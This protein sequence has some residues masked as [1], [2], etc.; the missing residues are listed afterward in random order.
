MYLTSDAGDAIEETVLASFKSVNSA[1]VQKSG[2]I[3]TM[4]PDGRLKLFDYLRNVENEIAEEEAHRK[5]DVE[6]VRAQMAR[7]FAFNK[8]ARKKMETRLLKR[9]AANA[10][11]CRD[12][13]HRAM[14]WTQHKFAKAAALA[15]KRQRANN[16]RYNEM[17]AKVKANKK[18]AERNL[19]SKVL[20]QQ[21]AMAALKS[22][23]NAKIRQTNHEV[24]INAAQIKQ[25]AKDAHKALMDDVAKFDQKVANARAEAAKGRSKLAA[26]LV[27]QNKSVRQYATNK[28]KEE[29]AKTANHFRRVRTKMAKD[30]DHA[31]RALKIASTRM[32]ASLNA[33]SAMN[34]KRFQKT[35]K[36]IAAAKKEARARVKAAK[37]A[38]KSHILELRAQVNQQVAKT[39][40]RMKQLSGV[41]EKAKLAQA[42]VNANVEA[43]MTRMMK[44]GNKRYQQH[45]AKDKELL[46]TINKN[47]A[48]NDKR[49]KA[50]A[51]HYNAEMNAVRKTMAKNRAH[52]SH[53]LAKESAKLYGAIAKSE[54]AQLKVN[55]AL[56]KQTRVAAMD[57]ADSLR[58]AKKDFARRMGALHTT[59]VANDKKFEKKIYKLTGIVHADAVKNAKGRAHLASV[60]KANKA[61]LK[62]AVSDAIQKG[63]EQMSNAESK[64]KKL[65]KKTQAAL[66]MRITG[67]ISKLAARANGQIEGLRLSS[68][69]ARAEMK[70]ELLFAVRSAA[71]EAKKNLAAAVK[72]ATKAFKGANKMTT[73][74][75]AKSAKDRA[76]IAAKIKFEKAQAKRGLK[77]A[78]GTMEKS[79]LALGIE[80]RK[81]IKKTNR[82]ITAYGNA[83][84]KESKTVKSLMKSNMNLLLGKIRSASSKA[85]KKIRKAN[86]KSRIGFG[87]VY[88]T[89]KKELKKAQK[90][91]DKKFAGMYTAMSKNRAQM[92]NNLAGAVRTMNKKIGMQ[93][94][95]FDARFSKTVKN[96]KN[97]RAEARKQ[98]ADARKSFATDLATLTASVKDQETRLNGDLE[99]VSAMHISNKAFQL[100]VNRRTNAEL[101]RVLKLSNDQH[102]E[103]KRARGKIRKIMDETKRAAAEEVKNM[104]RVFTGKIAKIR[105]R[106]GKDSIEAARDL[107]KASSRMYAELANV[108]LKAAYSNKLSAAKIAKYESQAAG[109]IASAK[110]N[111]NARLNNLAN[112]VVANSKKV[113]DG[114]ETLTG[115]IRT[116]KKKS[117]LDRQLIRAQIAAQEKDMN[118]RI[119]RAIAKGEADAKRVAER[120]RMDLNGMQKSMLV[121]I[122]E[123]VEETADNLFKTIQNKHKKL[124]D[125]YMS[126]KAYAVAAADTIE[127]EVS[128]GKGKALSS[129][130]DLLSTLAS[131]THVKVGKMPGLGL[132]GKSI[133]AIFKNVKYK[134]P[135]K[136]SKINALVAQY[137][138]VVNGVRARWPLGLG[139]YLLMK[140]E[141]SM[142]KKGVLKVGKVQDKSGNFVF[143]NGHAVGLSNKLNDFEKLAVRMSLY[144][145]ALARL[146]ADMAGKIPGMKK[147]PT[148]FAPPEYQGK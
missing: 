4:T 125:N 128:K 80:T 105:S 110:K 141:E 144:E 44:L 66:N 91:S 129:L 83:L 45:L 122:S 89:V 98:V 134:V 22:S 132:G 82:K 17:N 23:M 130:G 77:D 115:I 28:L 53:M 84:E 112:L 96:I 138:K 72:M 5:H 148:F 21:K 41:V 78:V 133:P 16:K 120:A 116:N 29:A 48:A 51:D 94:A 71:D 139:K 33:F 19:K 57:I 3:Y 146:T 119:V 20:A 56:A 118:K 69:E 79:L 60:M 108:Q 6:K 68:A 123:R 101:K 36:D 9:M 63:E 42:K 12:D 55:K 11:K 52:A 49:I 114:F 145:G 95:L 40:R 31:D 104:Q 58:N 102:S 92:E 70:K 30:R 74:A 75:N 46:K 147:K 38:F 106:A 54:A 88:R 73:A 8:N 86:L 64:L 87:N 135:G 24:S 111:F 43:E 7:N 14:V 90:A 107:S 47:K 10:K 61:E 39:N 100:R 121:E 137:S 93:A 136:V 99:V 18:A 81:K 62:K 127:D 59:V 65:N 97:A 131:I 143:L 34:T 25:N 50:M 126:L 142:L 13:L 1:D 124:A 15:N 35:M 76:E 140:L 27:R 32:H 109:K 37:V 113:A 2:D 117:A 26:Q 67:A 103:S 85:S